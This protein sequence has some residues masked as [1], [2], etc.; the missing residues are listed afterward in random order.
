MLQ[1]MCCGVLQD[2][3]AADVCGVLQDNVAADVLWRVAGQ[4]CS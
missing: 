4:C 1:L 2:N 3:V